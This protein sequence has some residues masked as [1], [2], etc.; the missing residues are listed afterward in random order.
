MPAVAVPEDTP[1]L[2]GFIHLEVYASPL[3]AE[4]LT[5]W[6]RLRWGRRLYIPGVS[7][8][9]RSCSGWA[10]ST[11]NAG[12][13]YNDGSAIYLVADLVIKVCVCR[14]P[15][16][17]YFAVFRIEYVQHSGRLADWNCWQSEIVWRAST[18]AIS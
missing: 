17:Y 1:R 13:A 5:A 9:Y 14:I 18:D 11:Q 8:R 12:A 15:W 16:R 3:V 10:R 2:G 7:R 4:N 6:H